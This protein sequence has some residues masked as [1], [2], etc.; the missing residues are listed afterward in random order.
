MWTDFIHTGAAIK[1]AT[2]SDLHIRFSP[3]GD[4]AIASYVLH[5][6][7]Q[8]ADKSVTDEND[9]ETDVWFKRAGNWKIAHVHYSAAPKAAA[10]AEGH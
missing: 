10:A 8:N 2:L 4:T 1:A 5:L 7:T 3:S 6:Q 9:Q